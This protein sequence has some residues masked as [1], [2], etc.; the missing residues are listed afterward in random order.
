LAG[1][2]TEAHMSMQ[3]TTWNEKELRHVHELMHDVNVKFL[4]SRRQNVGISHLSERDGSRHGLLGLRYYFDYQMEISKGLEHVDLF[5]CVL[6][7][8]QDPN[9]SHT[10][11]QLE[12]IAQA[13]R[14]HVAQ[15]G[16]V[17]AVLRCINAMLFDLHRFGPAIDRYYH[18]DSSALGKVLQHKKGGPT[19]LGLIYMSVARQAGLQVTPLS[20]P[21]HFLLRISGDGTDVYADPYAGGKLYSLDQVAKLLSDN[22]QLPL[23]S[24]AASNIVPA[25]SAVSSGSATKAHQGAGPAVDMEQAPT[26]QSSKASTVWF[27]EYLQPASNEDILMRLLR[28]LREVYWVP[29]LRRNVPSKQEKRMRWHHEQALSV[30]RLMRLTQPHHDS[31]VVDEALCLVGLH[32]RSE[33]MTLLAGYLQQHPE[34][35]QAIR[36]QYLLEQ[37]AEALKQVSALQDEKMQAKL[38]ERVKHLGPLDKHPGFKPDSNYYSRALGRLWDD[39]Y[40]ISAMLDN[41]L[42]ND[43]EGE[44]KGKKDSKGKKGK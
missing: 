18:P 20:L 21:S 34:S 30:L 15:K 5:K 41:Q 17:M 16:D 35:T 13:V 36:V 22:L 12:K 3:L 42:F 7:I 23:R 28:N 19:A 9:P 10:M 11:Q 24:P 14:K 43:G 37:E 8:T 1:N 39:N 6:L 25:P 26:R 4:E 27:A 31:H 38:K 2:V 29:L 32:R 33:A 44:S 40:W